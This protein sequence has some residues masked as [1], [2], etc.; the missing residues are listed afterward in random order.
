MSTPAPVATARLQ[1]SRNAKAHGSR[2]QLR[3]GAAP[4]SNPRARWVTQG[5][6]RPPPQNPKGQ[7]LVLLTMTGASSRRPSRRSAFSELAATS[8]RTCSTPTSTRAAAHA[9]Q[10]A[11]WGA[12][13]CVCVCVCCAAY[14]TAPPP[15]APR[16]PRL[17]AR[18]RRHQLLR[19]VMMAAKVPAV[20][21]AN[22]FSSPVN[23]AAL[24]SEVRQRRMR[25]RGDAARRAP[26]SSASAGALGN[27][28]R[29]G[30]RLTFGDCS[31]WGGAASNRGGD[32]A[33][34]GAAEAVSTPL[35][36]SSSAPADT[37]RCWTGGSPPVRCVLR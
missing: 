15:H 2:L 32:C 17:E 28:P 37:A 13:A 11:A 20:A 24:T 4:P 25:R 26:S 36:L 22:A 1:K 9:E 8:A 35:C 10:R 12:R 31:G 23:M 21:T 27:G 16:A 33:A 19:D 5:R 30:V 3:R 34:G 6:Q 14:P 29:F 7:K 18:D